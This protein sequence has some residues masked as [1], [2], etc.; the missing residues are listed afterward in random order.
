MENIV[1]ID[2]TDIDEGENKL[3]DNINPISREYVEKHNIKLS[4]WNDWK[5]QIKNS[6]VDNININDCENT[7]QNIL[8]KRITPYYQSLV[9]NNIELSKTTNFDPQELVISKFESYDSLNEDLY[10][11]TKCI[12]HKYEDRVLFLCTN[13]CSVNCRF[14]TRSRIFEDSTNPLESISKKDIDDSINY[15]SNHLE[16]REVI[17][18]GGDILT[19]S[20]DKIEYIL[21][22]IRELKHVQIIRIGTKSLVTLPQRIDNQLVSMLKRYSPLYICGHFTHPSEITTECKKA[23]NLLVDNGLVLK[24]QTVLL[25]GVN[26]DI[27]VM[28]ELFYEL[29]MIRVNP[30]Y[31]FY[32]DY[33]VGSA[34]FRPTIDIG[35][36]IISE[37]R[38][39]SGFCVPTFIVDTVYGKIAVNPENILKNN[40]NFIELKSNN[41]DI[42]KIVK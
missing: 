41:G 16:I 4:D 26:D 34:H 36:S 3:L 19:L 27:S 5:W 20:N 9:E 29:L 10:K 14:C 23:C 30:Y 17:L 31:I 28:K 11:K 15:I 35:L 37:L 13:F 38:K 12:V 33:V 1:C 2:N 22:G 32:P 25:K 39:C 8:K 6:I 24:S 7:N 18:S 21:K 40:K 42:V